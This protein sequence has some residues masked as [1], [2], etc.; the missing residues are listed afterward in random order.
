MDEFNDL[1]KELE[2][3]RAELSVQD[4]WSRQ[5]QAPSPGDYWKHRLEEE[6]T[7]FNKKLQAGE[8][9]KKALEARLNKQQSEIS[10][11]NQKLSE[12]EKKFELD[13]RA[14]EDRLKTK[15]AELLME[16]NRLMWED[17]IRRTEFD[18]K[19]LLEKVSAL[20]AEIIALKDAQAAERAKLE[21]DFN[22]ERNGYH[23][24][25]RGN[26]ESIQILQE[27]IFELENRLNER[28]AD[29][30]DEKS[31][32][33]AELKTAAERERKFSAD[34]DTFRKEKSIL[35][36]EVSRLKAK[37]VEDKTKVEYAFREMS[38]TF[39]DSW[40]R[41]LGE[42]SGLAK[43][44]KNNRAHNSTWSVMGEMLNKIEE[45][46]E[47]LAAQASVGAGIP[48][49]F[50]A[51]II[52]TEDDTASWIKILTGSSA[53]LKT[54]SASNWKREI[55]S[56]KPRVLIVSA[57]NIGIALKAAAQWPFLP[58]VVFGEL[59]KSK[60]RKAAVAGFTTVAVPSTDA[61]TMNAVNNAALKS[62]ARTEFW[63]K[64]KVRKSYGAAVASAAC[65]LAAGAAALVYYAKPADV[66][67]VF[68]P[69][70]TVAFSTQ[71]LQPTNVTYDG[72]N[73]WACDWFGQSIY[74]HK[75]NGELGISRIFYFPN[76][77][78][79]ALAWM[80]GTLWSADAVD[81]RIYKHNSDENMSIIATFK[82]P[83]P[84]PS[85]LAGDGRILWSCDASTAK[86]Y[87]HKTNGELAVDKEYNAP[88]GSPSGLYYDG[89]YLWSTDSKTNRIYKH[90]I[91]EDL[92]VVETILPPG[93]EQ[94]GYN[95]SGIT[96]S[97]KYFWVC[98]EKAGRIYQYPAALIVK[99]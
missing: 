46:T 97:G 37:S 64:I 55:S 81:Q 8:E 20:N 62:P 98:S 86:I 84:A 78:F 61:E 69:A 6:K 77:H 21:N 71:Y 65:L 75:V 12:L 24:R 16:K 3:L 88:A 45:E 99:Q 63:D 35:Q 73:L 1:D 57:K 13:T 95:L 52:A 29:L 48:D 94:K 25:M 19:N 74:K 4:E 82:S 17:N 53:E 11:Y 93:Y 43:F 18:N 7:L 70:K 66:T 87:R 31:K 41:A 40:R 2:R 28:V 72:Q 44:M 96:G 15:E 90:R 51:A 83:G 92:T 89:E 80:N 38:K 32:R 36:D 5:F 58:V 9:E 47:L 26:S 30:E 33:E 14:W 68:A 59:K 67:A 85:G 34:T 27:R 76:R 60:A 91:D 49:K 56:I 42:V 10:G 39:V 54:A 50:T 23:E 22:N 79:S